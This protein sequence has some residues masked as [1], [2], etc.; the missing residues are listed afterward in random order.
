MLAKLATIVWSNFIGISIVLFL[1]VLN[2]VE[3]T[4]QNAIENGVDHTEIAD[5]SK[6][7][8]I[9]TAA[10]LPAEFKAVIKPDKT[11]KEVEINQNF[12]INLAIDI[13][14]FLLIVGLIYYPNYKRLDTIFTFV[15]FNIS[16]CLLTFLVN[17]V[18]ISWERFSDYLPY[19][20]CCATER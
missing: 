7:L 15:L 18:K 6:S 19:F 11:Q 17:Q 13:V 14:A 12:F 4:A 8:S 16:I 9:K 5:S 1:L 2:P 20:R 10:K 3:V